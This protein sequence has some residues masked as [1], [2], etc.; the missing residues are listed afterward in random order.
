MFTVSSSLLSIGVLRTDR[1]GD[2]VLNTQHFKHGTHRTT[3]ND[4]RTSR[5]G[6]HDHLTGAVTAF[7]V[8]VQGAALFQRYADHL[9][10]GL[11]GRLADRLGH[12]FRFT[13]AKAYGAFLIA[14]NNKCSETKALTTFDGFRNTVDRNQTI[15]KFRCFVAVATVPAPM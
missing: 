14:D 9:A 2:H 15:C 1:L 11:L 5:S 12:F 13:L 6:A 3:G 7:H 10:L 8:V 4:T